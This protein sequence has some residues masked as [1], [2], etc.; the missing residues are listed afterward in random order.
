MRGKITKSAVDNLASKDARK[1]SCGIAKSRAL[2]SGHG[3]VEQRRTFST[4]ELALDVMRR[5]VNSQS[6][7][8]GHLGR[9]RRH[10]SKPSDF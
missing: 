8:M 3:A 6:A 9:R 1:S 2:A 10:V 4:I 5:C 7:D